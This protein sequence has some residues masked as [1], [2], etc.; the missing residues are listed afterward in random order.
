MLGVAE[1]RTTNS[2]GRKLR[3]GRP[4]LLCLHRAERG[5]DSRA[6]PAGRFSREPDFRGPRDYR[7]D[8][9][10]VADAL[11]SIVRCSHRP[12]AGPRLYA[13][14]YIRLTT[15]RA[16]ATAMPTIAARDGGI[17]ARPVR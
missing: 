2:V 15:R 8:H 16:V 10:R 4:D 1:P 17:K 12:V 7:S 5:I 14:F 6:R 13:A 11:E 9:C 3:D